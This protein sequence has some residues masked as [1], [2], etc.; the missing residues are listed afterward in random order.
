[1][2]AVLTL[3]RRCIVRMAM[4]ELDKVEDKSVTL[5]SSHNEL[6][7]PKNAI[8]TKSRP[9]PADRLVALRDIRLHLTPRSHRAY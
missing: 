5:F 1:M 6:I 9:I 3:A 2:D 8:G 7:C 4:L